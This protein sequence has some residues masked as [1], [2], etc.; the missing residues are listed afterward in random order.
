[1]FPHRKKSA[2]V[3]KEMRLTRLVA[4]DDPDATELLAVALDTG[5]HRVA[6]KRAPLADPLQGATP[7]L[8]FKSKAVRYDVYIQNP[9]AA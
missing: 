9:A 2:L 1:M 8:T 6:V 5:A 3:K 7:S 4:G